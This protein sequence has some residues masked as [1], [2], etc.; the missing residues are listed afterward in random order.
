M[1]EKTRCLIPGKLAAGERPSKPCNKLLLVF[2]LLSLI[3]GCGWFCAG[4][5]SELR[6]K[7][8]EGATIGKLVTLRVAIQECFG[9]ADGKFPANLEEV[10]Q[11]LPGPVKEI[12]FA[13]TALHG[14]ISAIQ[15]ISGDDYRAGKISDTGGWAYVN[16]PGD[17][18]QGLVMVNCVHSRYKQTQPWF[19][20]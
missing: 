10:K 2:I 19:K 3:G 11:Y 9:K 8:G 17:I 12:P 5:F 13:H 6:I 16:T 7:A 14:K 4:K 15:Y 1:E 20:H 18:D